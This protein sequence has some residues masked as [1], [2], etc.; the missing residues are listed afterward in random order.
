MGETKGGNSIR[1]PI[2]KELQIEGCVSK[3]LGKLS[4]TIQRGESKNIYV[5]SELDIIRKQN[6]NNK[7]IIMKD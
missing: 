7:L 6:N 4:D 5:N 2:N 3:K 1:F